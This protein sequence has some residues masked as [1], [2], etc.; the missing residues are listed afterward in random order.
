MSI[1]T[2][3]RSAYSNF[4]SAMTVKPT[5]DGLLKLVERTEKKPDFKYGQ[6]IYI[7]EGLHITE[8]SVYSY[9]KERVYCVRANGVR[10]SVQRGKFFLTAEE[11]KGANP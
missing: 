6:T 8:L 10:T 4:R 11:A 2:A 5:A 1:E 9:D 3:V 7:K